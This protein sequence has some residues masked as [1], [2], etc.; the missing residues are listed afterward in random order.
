M[1][2]PNIAMFIKNLINKFLLRI[3]ATRIVRGTPPARLEGFLASVRPVATEHALIRLGGDSDGGYL[4][5]DD[6]AGVRHCFSPGVADVATFE[7][8]LAARGVRSFMADFSVEGPPSP[9]GHFSFEKKYLG[10]RDDDMSTTLESWVRRNVPEDDD[11]ILQM[12]IEGAEYGVLLSTNV[13]VLRRF[14]I[15]VIE[16][17]GMESLAEKRGCEL[18]SLAFDR[19]LEDFDVVHAH[20][21]N[22]AQPINY[23]GFQLPPVMEFTFHRKDRAR[24][25]RPAEA[26]PHPLDRPNIAGRPDILLPA[27][28][29]GS[30]E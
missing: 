29:R 12:D 11:M 19:L 22:C 30:R 26:F 18:I 8:H 27:C 24:T 1:N 15:I 5:P 14:R 16:F 25:R 28:W 21:N 20:V 4:V 17:H 2:V 3:G 6:L 7:E 9:N 10:P 13:E 23:A